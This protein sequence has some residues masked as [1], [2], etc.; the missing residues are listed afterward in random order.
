ML[1]VGVLAGKDAPRQLGKS[2]KKK[3]SAYT[4]MRMFSFSFRNA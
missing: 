4:V 3:M 2:L 1:A